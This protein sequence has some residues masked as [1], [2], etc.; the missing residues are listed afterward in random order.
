MKVLVVSPHPDDEV[1]GAGGSIARLASEGNE[2]TVAIATKGWEPLFSDSQV[3]QV[4]AEARVAN[5]ILGVK[6]L[7]FMD[8]PV[9]KLN[10][11]PKHELNGKFEQL[12]SEEEP[13]MVFLPFGGD[14]QEDH[15]QVF[16][17]CMVALRPAASGKYV[18]RI[19]CYETVSETHWCSGNIEARFEP[20]LWMDISEHLPA[21]LE[22]MRS[23]K[24]QLQQEPDARSLE[25]VT[26]LAKWRGSMVGMSAAECFVVVRECW[27]VS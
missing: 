4:R 25:A 16:R 3:E 21:K 11:L 10:E 8:M 24:S 27:G 19:L 22:A 18:R 12:M 15:G 6:T 23:Y 2:V 20:H 17:A 7:R 9:T 13:E 5:E 26:S 1:L 14:L